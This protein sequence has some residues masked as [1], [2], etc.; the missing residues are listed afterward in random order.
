MRT[1]RRTPGA[2]RERRCS[3]AYR[4]NQATRTADLNSGKEGGRNEERGWA[5]CDLRYSMA[6][7]SC[8]EIGKALSRKGADNSTEPGVSE[9]ASVSGRNN[10]RCERNP[11]S[12]CETGRRNQWYG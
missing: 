12:S 1:K 11:R 10:G 3:I 2:R 8:D 7:E 5:R 9:Y 6:A 4:S